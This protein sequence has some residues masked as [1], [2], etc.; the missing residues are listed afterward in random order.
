MENNIGDEVCCPKFEPAIWDGKTFT[1]K[2]KR[3]IKDHV[4]TLFF[5]PLTLGKV[6][7]KLDKKIRTAGATLLDG[8]ALSEHTSMWNMDQYLAVDREVPGVVN[9]TLSGSFVCKVYEGPFED[10][11]KWM[12]DFEEYNKQNSISVKRWLMWYTTCPKC[13]KKY[14][15]NYVAIF[16]QLG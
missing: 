13:A 2:D 10:T 14:G 8:M 12:K 15:K 5:M 16:G 11:G 7:E 3:F 9:T 1:W 4:R 6:M